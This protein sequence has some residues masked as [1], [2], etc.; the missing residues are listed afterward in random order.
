MVE[1]VQKCSNED[2]VEVM[3]VVGGRVKSDIQED[4]FNIAKKPRVPLALTDD[5]LKGR[6]P[7]LIAFL[8]SV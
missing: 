4:A 8:T 1:A 7:I 2:L 3:K 5:W 6:N